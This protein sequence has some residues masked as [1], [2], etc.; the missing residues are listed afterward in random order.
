M[1]LDCW[2]YEP[3]IL[4]MHQN[5]ILVGHY[6]V[7]HQRPFS[8]DFNGKWLLQTANK[9]KKQQPQKRTRGT[10]NIAAA[11][12]ISID[13]NVAALLSELVAFSH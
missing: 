9:K 3:K 8:C 4:R 5:W 11:N 10:G 12:D 13:A 2:D 7:T 1:Q 6:W